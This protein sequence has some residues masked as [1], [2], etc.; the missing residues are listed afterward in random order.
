[1]TP[2]RSSPLPRFSGSGVFDRWAPRL[3]P[4]LVGLVPLLFVLDLRDTFDL[5]KVTFVYI[6]VIALAG[7]WAWTALERGEI[8]YR[9]TALDRPLL[10]FL[11]VALFALV[12]S[13]GDA[14]ELVHQLDDSNGG[15]ATVAGVLLFLHL[16]IAALAASRLPR[17]GRERPLPS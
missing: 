16:G 17:R 13:A 9:P 3:I 2:S 10:V 11:A 6:T 1:M 15:L 5:P 4:L 8:V 14:R 7:L 12:F